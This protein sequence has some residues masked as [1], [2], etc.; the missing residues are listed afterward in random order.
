MVDFLVI[1]IETVPVDIAASKLLTEEE[2][3]KKLNPIDSK[4]VA[5]G[6]MSADATW[7]QSGDDE[8]ALL[9]EMWM[10]WDAFRRANPGAPIVGFNHASFDMPFV[11][12][13][14]FLNNVPIIPFST[15]QLVDIRHKLAAYAYGEQRGKLKELAE[16]T[17]FKTL[18][19][20]GSDVTRLWEEDR[21]KLEE[22]LTRDLEITRALYERLVA[23]NIDKIQRF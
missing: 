12:T 13:R 22:Y 20:D 3:K 6:L 9:R 2:R 17:G 10:R 21:E 11:V 23:L 1:D 8:A 5:I 16:L 7:V 14:S 18:D 4:I 19:V 15:R